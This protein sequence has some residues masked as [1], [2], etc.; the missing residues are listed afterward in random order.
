MIPFEPYLTLYEHLPYETV[1]I[2]V[3]VEDCNCW[4]APSRP[5]ALPLTDFPLQPERNHHRSVF[6]RA[7]SAYFDLG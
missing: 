4:A 2:V 7:N 3:G 1:F 6:T 5:L